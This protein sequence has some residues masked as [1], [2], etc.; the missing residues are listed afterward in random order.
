MKQVRF[1]SVA[2]TLTAALVLQ[3]CT[4]LR[5]AYSPTIQNVPAFKEKNESRIN[6]VMSSPAS[7]TETNFALQG[8]YALTKHF[9]VLGSYNGTIKG[10][11]EL[12]YTEN[13]T[14][15]TDI[16]EYKRNSAEFG[17]GIF[18]PVSPNE[19]VV[20]EAYAGYGFGNNKI[21]DKTNNTVTGFHNSKTNRYFIQPVLSIHPSPSFTF[22]TSF[23]YTNI[24]Y[25]D[26]YTTYSVDDLA[27]YQL[28]ELGTKRISFLEPSI[29]LSG[30]L[31]DA[32]WV[33]LQCQMN[34]SFYLGGPTINYRS[35]YFSFGF[36][37]DP[38]KAIRNNK[39]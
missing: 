5:F 35:N 20:I 3:S 32:P 25:S 37:F 6:A 11:D 2:I 19:K 29:V 28:T 9:A 21:T 7:G 10:R 39:N 36:Q 12:S 33:R 18:Y 17:A 23:R 8:A 31:P 38:V 1:S 15:T 13:G 14:T 26:I 16:V 34:F 27:N 30:G 24:G 22:S 4:L